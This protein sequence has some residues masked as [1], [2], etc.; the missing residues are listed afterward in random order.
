MTSAHRQVARLSEGGLIDRTRPLRFSFDGRRFE[1]FAGDTLASALVANRVS[2]VGRSFKYHRPRG[3][4]SAGVEEPN[5]LVE[6]RGGARREPNTRA[7]VIELYDELEACSQNRWPTLRFDV[8]SLNQLFAPI[9]GAGFYYKTFMWP[10]KLW[11]KLY[12]PLIRRS[13]GL[14]RAANAADPDSYEKAYAF[15]DVLVVGSGPAGLMAA[16]IAA[17]SG[18]RVLLVEEDFRLGGRCLAE[19]RLIDGAPGHVWVSNV[20]RELEAMPNVRLMRRTT[21]F[22]CFDHGVFGAVERVNDH[23][24]VPP[25]FEP[26][27]RM[28]R[29]VAKCCAL[30]TG[31]IE[32][33]LVFGDNDR[34]GVMLAGSVRTYVNRF[35]ALPGRRAV[36]FTDNDDGWTTAA[37]LAAA[38]ASIVAI[39]DSRE[40][41][42]LGQRHVVSKATEVITGGVVRRAL[43]GITLQGAEISV[44]KTI[45]RVDCDL[46]AVSGGWTPTLHL[47]SHLGSRP[48]WGEERA[49]LL[50]DQLPP[51]M[52]IAGAANGDFTTAAALMSGARIGKATA[53]AIGRRV[54]NWKLP[55]VAPESDAHLPLWPARGAS[56][57]CFLDFQN[58]VTTL[59]M[60]IAVD[61][62]FRSVE[63]LKRYTTLGMATDQ[64]KTANVNGLAQLAHMQGEKFGAVGTTT[65][66]PPY[67][68]VP[69][70]AFAGQH[71]SHDFRPVRLTPAHQWAQQQGAVFA[72]A[73]LWMRPQYFPRSDETDWLATVSR[74][75][76]A[77]RTAVGVCDVSTLG[78][79]DLQGADA[80][81]FLDRL[82]T[83]IFTTLPVGRARYGL[84]LREDGFVMDDGTVARLAMSHF[85]ITTTTANAAA[86]FQ[87]WQFCHQVL[88]PELDVN[89]VSVTDQWAQY[90]IA[91]PYS[92]ALLQKLVERGID[93]A[94]EAF[95]FLA[96]KELRLAEGP[97]ARLFRISFSG[98][99]AYE[100]A[101][102][103]R[104]GE[105][106]LRSIF[107]AGKE[108]NVTPY[109]TEALGVL[110]IEKGH[111][112]GNELNGQTTATDL[113]LGRMLSARK[114]F[115]GAVLARRSALLDPTR[116]RLIGIKPLD[117]SARLRAGAHLIP[118]GSAPTAA[119]DQGYVSSVA[120]SPTLGHW[121]GLAFLTNG[122]ERHGQIIEYCD[123]LRH[124]TFRVEIC[125]PVF[126][127]P[128]GDRN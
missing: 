69:I 11:E 12:E 3:L 126:L 16:L 66:R 121:I 65:Y 49:A 89:F 53:E 110:R 99:L 52:H 112:A 128:T 48:R 109:G 108:F 40:Q 115:I 5:G 67:T 113:G 23:V 106:I 116:P 105:P 122:A 72:E 78:K 37:D 4:L 34:P 47:A 84:M 55:L 94:N 62:G 25:E 119:N 36:V 85:V 21:V 31:A 73:G 59:D 82:Y 39:V 15:C 20:I 58:D 124:Q 33:P 32:R 42:T 60:E 80:A 63:H 22:G 18:A 43:G 51:G 41:P 87:H 92:R 14:G 26:R 95:P 117:R 102:P 103:A 28:W 1:G 86:V 83:N 6:L 50:A 45:R 64:G 10:A 46:L 2:L 9:L 29:I 111:V 127:D 57:K 97:L 125:N 70:G 54:A 101:V 75:V 90:A 68:P 104:L 30:A 24:L 100:I 35:A 38:G 61:E 27:Q 76:T 19:R 93:L 79:I 8:R 114:D 120:L 13:A 123:P 81:V 74:E 77:V 88:W 71:R 91:G 107:E 7:T 98:E 56:G 44:G 17:R 96:A 118:E